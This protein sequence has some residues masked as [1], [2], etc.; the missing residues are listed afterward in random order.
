MRG[1]SAVWVL[2]L[3]TCAYTHA[4]DSVQVVNRKRL[5]TVILVG[6]TGYALTL[7]GLNEL[8]YSESEK[9]S[10]TFFNDNK[11][12][13]QVDKAGHF[14]SA[15]HFSSATSS[16]LQWSN[17][18]KR[19]AD[20]WGSFT[21]FMIMLPIEI[22]DGFSADYGASVGDLLANASGSAFF[23]AQSVL[24]NEVRFHPKFSF[25][26]TA[27]PALRTDGTLGNGMPSEIFKDY[28]G[29]TYWL[30][31]DLDK[32]FRFPRWLNLAFGYGAHDM[33]YARDNE[34][35]AAGYNAYRQYYVGL[36]L[37]LSHIK[38]NSKVLNTALF[39]INM[40]KLPAPAFEFSRKGNSFTWFQF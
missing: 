25:Q 14:Y 31:V 3:L 9:Q 36:D 35:S 15:F 32:F 28:N 26:R 5:N 18:E 34:N 22:M 4:Q 29:Q 24:W 11:E 30:S 7:Y 1:T 6:G 8:W 20:L 39:L 2:V 37:D 16:L 21:G 10:F 38:T 27:Y 12:W 13:K 19:K 40:I 33:V 17:V 23:L